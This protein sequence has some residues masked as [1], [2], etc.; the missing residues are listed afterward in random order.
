MSGSL[1]PVSE[2]FAPLTGC[3]VDAAETHA[4]ETSEAKIK[5]GP[6]VGF[7]GQGPVK[8]RVLAVGC[9]PHQL[10]P[11]RCANPP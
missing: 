8:A 3:K 10:L 4:A 2:D 5:S 1:T 11:V 6:A 9:G 7:P